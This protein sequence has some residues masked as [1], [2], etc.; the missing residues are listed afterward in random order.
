MSINATEMI[1]KLNFVVSSRQLKLK[2]YI[3]DYSLIPTNSAEEEE[4]VRQ[5]VY[6]FIKKLFPSCKIRKHTNSY[7]LRLDSHIH[8]KANKLREVYNDESEWR[9][10]FESNHSRLYRILRENRTA[11][12][13]GPVDR[14][15]DNGKVFLS[16]P[17]TPT[18]IRGY[19]DN[20]LT[21]F[22][23]WF[24]TEYSRDEKL[25]EIYEEAMR[26]M[27]EEIAR[28]ERVKRERIESELR[29]YKERIYNQLFKP[30][31]ALQESENAI[32]RLFAVKFSEWARENRKNPEYAVQPTAEHM[33]TRGLKVKIMAPQGSEEEGWISLP[34]FEGYTEP[35]NYEMQGW[36]KV[37]S[38]DMT[39]ERSRNGQS[40]VVVQE[41]LYTEFHLEH[42]AHLLPEGYM[43]N[44]EIANRLRTEAEAEIEPW[45]EQ[46]R[47][48][49]EREEAEARAR[50][51]ERL[52]LQEIERLE[53]EERIR[54]QAQEREILQAAEAEREASQAASRAERE[55]VLARQ[56]REQLAEA[57]AQSPM[58]HQQATSLASVDDFFGEDSSVDEEASEA[59]DSPE[60]NADLL[61]AFRRQMA[62]AQTAPEQATQEGVY[63][64][65][66]AI[67]LEQYVAITASG[68]IRRFPTVERAIQWL[69]YGNQA[70][71]NIRDFHAPHDTVQVI[72]QE[73]TPF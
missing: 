19:A 51:E 37:T 27:E 50:E 14:R 59:S 25:A 11:F 53:V 15:V 67:P 5:T 70:Q 3:E 7:S 36:G 48:R 30:I 2:N 1:S 57:E 61:A 32:D 49:K 47:I 60:P 42:W 44:V 24:E 55:A 54:R 23:R 62:Q 40:P 38:V 33:V 17:S 10:W 45:L 56:L 39:S 41:Y 68:T 21:D 58:G 64:N 72:Q 6:L 43:E 35:E 46:E 20:G 73:Q 65:S 31:A 28:K 22:C 16:I 34:P 52:R 18:R 66:R 71:I 4:F 26:L 9:Q 29:E 13:G 12:Q 69:G 8:R 63:R